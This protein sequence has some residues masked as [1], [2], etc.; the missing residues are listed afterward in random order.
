[1]QSTK[2]SN[3]SPEGQRHPR[4]QQAVRVI[5][6]QVNPEKDRLVK[7]SDSR[8]YSDGEGDSQ[9]E[10]GIAESKGAGHHAGDQRYTPG[11]H[12]RRKSARL[13]IATMVLKKLT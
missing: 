13:S 9:N 5:K 2:A 11:H 4:E 7:G 6:K 3:E 12:H 10:Q 1:M 8:H